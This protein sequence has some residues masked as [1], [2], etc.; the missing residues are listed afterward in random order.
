M[1]LK[2]GS[3][4]WYTLQKSQ[5]CRLLLAALERA[6]EAGKKER[7]VCKLREQFG[8][9]EQINSDLT[10]AVAVNLASVY[11]AAQLYTEALNSFTQIVRSKQFPQVTTCCAVCCIMLMLHMC[12]WLFCLPA[13]IIIC[14]CSQRLHDSNLSHQFCLPVS[15]FPQAA[16]AYLDVVMLRA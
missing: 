1:T 4:C 9:L 10:Y 16:G 3:V 13:D 11:Q 14:M 15:M 2:V 5:L 7:A 8:L 12:S 6:K